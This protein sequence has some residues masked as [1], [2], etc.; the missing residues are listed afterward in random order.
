MARIFADLTPLRES[1]PF[2]RLWIGHSVGTAGQQ[3]TSVAVA[4]EVY[5]LTGSSLSVGL[6]GFFQLVPLVVLG[7]YGGA[8][9]DRFDRRRVA[10]FST[11]GL[12]GSTLAF[13]AQ[14]LAG[15]NSVALLY[16]IIAVQSGFFA[17]ANPARQAIIPRLVPAHLL[18]AANALNTLTWGLA[19]TIGP[20]V[21]G[22]LVAGTGTVTTVY[23]LDLIVFAISVWAMWRLP[24]LPPE[25]R[26]PDA[27]RG[28]RSVWDGIRFLKGKRNLQM[29]FY[30]DIVAM[31]FGM[32]RALF[33]AIA[34]AWYGGSLADVALI[35]GLLSAAPAV[36]SITATVLSGPLGK[37]RRQGRAVVMSICVWG[38]AIA[39][40]GLVRELPVALILLAIAGGADSV[41]AIF[42]TT[43]LQAATPDDYRGRLQGIYTVVVVGGPRLGDVEAG[44]VAEVFGEAVSAVSGGVLCLV[45]TGA[46]VAAVPAFLR[47]DAERP[48]P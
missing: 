16:A 32:P 21:A 44:A 25:G 19:F 9:L 33:P 15:L 42:R 8:L 26:A 36:G 22:F 12:W 1:P 37:V 14:S 5:D 29:S 30:L 43:I 24:S 20:V 40:F 6:T 46:L 3:M 45:F 38:S 7:L 4:L 17:I 28:W 11:M 10:L 39:V 2:R 48:V 13:V 34:T 41:S 35:V 18:P 47:Y 27:A 31:V 23:A